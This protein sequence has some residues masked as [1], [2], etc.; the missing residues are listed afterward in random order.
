MFSTPGRLLVRGLAVTAGYFNGAGG[1]VLDD[2]GFFDTGDIATIDQY[3]AVQ[4]TDRAKDV[5]KSGGEW[6]SSIELENAALRHPGVANAAAIGV[7]D[8]KW[9]ERPVLVIE[10]RPGAEVTADELR[11]LLT[12]KIA[13]WWMPDDFVFVDSIPLGATGKIN[14]LALRETIRQRLAAMEHP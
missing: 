6:I 8:P 3:G 4:I 10:R 9:D 1:A 5:I 13:R 14:K 11:A 2:Q 12:G 7:P